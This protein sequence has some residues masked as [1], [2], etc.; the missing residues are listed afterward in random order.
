MVALKLVIRDVE[1]QG[2]ESIAFYLTD[3]E[4]LRGDPPNIQ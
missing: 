3:P 4:P 2:F 1:K